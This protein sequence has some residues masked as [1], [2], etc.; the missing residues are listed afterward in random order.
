ML[1]L[2]HAL[3]GFRRALPPPPPSNDAAL[4]AGDAARPAAPIIVAGDYNVD[5]GLDA[6]LPTPEYT[7]L[8][9][10]LGATDAAV[11][12]DEALEALLNSY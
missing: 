7:A 8:V 1:E 12:A 2:A 3:R 6:A 4:A 9:H 5:A 11:E 10:A